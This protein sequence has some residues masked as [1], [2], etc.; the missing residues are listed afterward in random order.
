M[1]KKRLTVETIIHKTG[2]GVLNRKI[3]TI[4]SDNFY[5]LND[6]VGGDAPKDVIKVYEY[7]NGKCR[8]DKPKSWTKYIAKIG[9]KWY[10]NESITEH[11]LTS[12]GVSFG[13]K[14]ANSK[15]ASI[16]NYIRFMSE[17]FHSKDQELIHGANILSR[18]INESNNDWIDK[19]DKEKTL[20]GEINILD[21][22]HAIGDVFP[23]QGKQIV[24]SLINMILFDCL[25]GNND[26]H[27]YNWG[28]IKHIKNRHE[29]FFSPIYDTA[30]GLFWNLDDKN[31]ISL[32]SNLNNP[33]FKRVKKYIENSAPKISV[34][35]NDKCNHFELVDYLVKNDY[36]EENHKNGWTNKEN[37]D[38]A[39]TILRTDFKTLFIK[40]RIEL[41][42]KTLRIRFGKLSEIMLN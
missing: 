13:I 5:V 23:K 14:I 9:H 32:H 15:L 1:K 29:P 6:S 16:E 37:L 35:D 3:D 22:I 28:V 33:D 36:I 19:M 17:H 21:V 30:R 4:K 12:I 42:E 39:L 20:R 34:P 26:R 24:N 7:K 41:I 2:S 38:K 25:I 18:F 10:P 8:K 11:Y 40:E 27:Y 31:I